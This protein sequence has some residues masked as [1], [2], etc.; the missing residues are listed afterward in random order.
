M[1]DPPPEAGG[2]VGAEP[3]AVSW[4]WH[5]GAPRSEQHVPNGH[6][7]LAAQTLRGPTA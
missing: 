5:P 3:V 2:Q 7:G 1:V 6:G 4:G